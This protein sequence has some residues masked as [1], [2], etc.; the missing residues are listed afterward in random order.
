MVHLSGRAEHCFMLRRLALAAGLAG[1]CAALVLPGRAVADIGC[2]SLDATRIC[3]PAEPVPP[4][5]TPP[6]SPSPSPEPEPEPAPEPSPS[7]APGGGGSITDDAGATTR[8]LQLVNEDRAKEGLGPMASRDDVAT[9]ARRHSRSM[10]EQG[11]ISHNDSYFTAATRAALAA[12]ALGEN[13]AQNSSIDDAHRRLMASPGHRA[14]VLDGRFSVIGIGVVR[15]GNGR[16]FVTEDFVAPKA[17][18]VK[19][20]G[21]ARPRA[22]GAASPPPAGASP[23]AADAQAEEPTPPATDEPEAAPVVELD[24]A[25]A[26][27]ETPSSRG[28]VAA[29]AVALAALLAA[30]TV[31]FR[32]LS[33]RFGAIWAR[34]PGADHTESG[35]WGHVAITNSTR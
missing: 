20:A 15:D 4:G 26:G 22:G 11:E 18:A 35:I 23:T 27:R 21:V 13:V 28:R 17:V 31:T 5:V 10:A 12:K 6:P 8:L 3:P 33:P 25:P 1:I 30:S 29:L 24:T 34:G 16:L 19:A 14:N 7:P 9:I 32:T 2:S